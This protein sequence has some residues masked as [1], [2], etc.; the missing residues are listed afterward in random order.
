[1]II[2]CDHCRVLANFIQSGEVVR[3]YPH[4]LVFWLYVA[5]LIMAIILAGC[6]IYGFIKKWK[7]ENK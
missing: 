2:Y 6:G 3:Q 7:K 4:P 1:M 5:F